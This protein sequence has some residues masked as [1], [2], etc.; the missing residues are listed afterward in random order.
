M[1]E[2]RATN[3][4]GIFG[5]VLMKGETMSKN[6]SCT[7]EWE[8]EPAIGESMYLYA[9]LQC[10]C[11][12]VIKKGF[13]SGLFVPVRATDMEIVC[14][15][16]H[17]IYVIKTDCPAAFYYTWV[18]LVTGS[19]PYMTLCGIVNPEYITKGEEKFVIGYSNNTC[20]MWTGDCCRLGHNTAPPEPTGS[21]ERRNDGKD[22]DGD[23]STTIPAT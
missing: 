10:S 1:E 18:G 4:T 5:A 2:V 13:G 14:T 15:A 12:N 20:S 19:C 21:I 6:F 7:F 9:T 8:E 16:C 23:Q 3:A 17:E 11:G 22:N